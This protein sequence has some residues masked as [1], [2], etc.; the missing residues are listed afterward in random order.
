MKR[1]TFP[2]LMLAFCAL[3]FLSS[4][5][6]D[7]EEIIEPIPNQ[8]FLQEMDNVASATAAGWTFTNKSEPIG[9]TSWANGPQSFAFS[10]TGFITSDYNATAGAGIISNWAISPMLTLQN[11]DRIEFYAISANDNTDP[12]NVYP[13]RLQLLISKTGDINIGTGN[14]KGSFEVIVDINAQ[15]DNT[16]PIAFP[17]HWTKFVGTVVGLNGPVEGR[18]AFRYYVEDGGPSGVNSAAIGIDKVSYIGQ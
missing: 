4:C 2:A 11:G 16:P 5:D 8:S 6:D 17:D 7:K 13:D 14:D 15:Y 1:S 9:T 18:F 3:P 12:A 10:G